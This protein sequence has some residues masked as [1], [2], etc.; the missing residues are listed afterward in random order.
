MNNC[1]LYCLDGNICFTF[2]K[3]SHWEN[4]L[5]TEI[6]EKKNHGMLKDI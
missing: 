6:L 4:N 1:K 3:T 2:S 5:N